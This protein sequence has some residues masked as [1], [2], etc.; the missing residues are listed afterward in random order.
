MNISP[1][2]N[3]F[4]KGAGAVMLAALVSYLADSA[5]LQGIM[6][7]TIATIVAGFALVLE[8]KIKDKTGNSLFGAAKVS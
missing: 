8:G 2:F 5:N 3:R 1:A 7:P 4:L 6:N